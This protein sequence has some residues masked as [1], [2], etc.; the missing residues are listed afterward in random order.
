M[1]DTE[2]AQQMIILPSKI[3][4]TWFVEYLNG[5]RWVKQEFDTC[6]SAWAYYYT[7]L[8]DLRNKIHEI[9]DPLW[10]GNK[11]SGTRKRIYKQLSDALGYEYHTGNTRTIEECRT[12]YRLVKAMYNN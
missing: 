6:E 10:Q 12:V 9:L 7:K 11:P 5:V 3:N 2:K 8:K 1:T 4:G